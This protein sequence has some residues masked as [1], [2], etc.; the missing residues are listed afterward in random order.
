M[1]YIRYLQHSLFLSLSFLRLLLIVS[2]DHIFCFLFHLNFR[3]CWGVWVW[4]CQEGQF[5]ISVKVLNEGGSGIYCRYCCF[6]YSRAILRPNGAVI[7]ML[8]LGTSSVNINFN[9]AVNTAVAAGV[10]VVVY[11]AG[12]LRTQMLRQW[13]SPARGLPQCSA[14]EKMTRYAI[15]PT[16]GL[17][18]RSF[19][20]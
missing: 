8:S 20:P 16:F 5:L 12:N 17:R 14:T 18:L 1:W 19:A 4:D 13:V 9:T 11:R 2:C 7:N 3:N 15:L 6:D 10:T